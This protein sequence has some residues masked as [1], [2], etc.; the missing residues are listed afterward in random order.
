MGRGDDVA[1]VDECVFEICVAGEELGAQE[2][3]VCDGG[4]EGGV[5]GCGGRGVRKVDGG[6]ECHCGLWG[7]VLQAEYLK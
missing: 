2:G 1:G 3:G 6:E 7:V 5:E 4:M